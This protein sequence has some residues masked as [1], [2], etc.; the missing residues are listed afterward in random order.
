MAA[1]T[2]MI[3]AAVHQQ[4]PGFYRQQGHILPLYLVIVTCVE[5][6]A[7]ITILFSDLHKYG[8]LLFHDVSQ[9]ELN[10]D[11]YTAITQDQLALRQ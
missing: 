2:D 9:G 4:T 8:H 3:A 11:C 1:A 5:L 10:C 6:R 7:P